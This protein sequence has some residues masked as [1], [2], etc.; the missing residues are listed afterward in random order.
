MRRDHVGA[1]PRTPRRAK[2]S[3][4][5]L[6][7]ETDDTA[8]NTSSYQSPS[9]DPNQTNYSTESMRPQRATA[10]KST[11]APYRSQNDSTRSPRDMDLTR[12]ANRNTRASVGPNRTPDR[13]RAERPQPGPSRH[14]AA[15]KQPRPRRHRPGVKA[16]MEIRRYQ[17]TV[18]TL[19]P[20]LPFSRVVREVMMN[21][22]RFNAQQMRITRDALMALQESAEMYLT[23]FFEDSLRLTIHAK[24]VTLMPRDMQ[25]VSYLR[26]NW[27][28]L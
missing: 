6:G 11:A 14:A 26:N 19:I 18:N 9:P 17:N 10:R 24:R 12:G 2:P 7:D 13:S 21:N 28:L 25:L 4:N 8:N 22:T 15:R 16:L 3:N 20:K 1:S 23:N 27:G 5:P